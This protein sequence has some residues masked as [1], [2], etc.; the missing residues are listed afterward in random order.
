VQQS[1]YALGHSKRELERLTR[2]AHSMRMDALIGGG[3]DCV[4]Y[5]LIAEVVEA[6]LPEIER[7]RIASAAEVEIS[8]LARRMRD[9]VVARKGVVLSPG[10][11]GAWSRKNAP[12]ISTLAY[13]NREGALND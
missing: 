5:Q 2:Q 11:I 3:L 13:R 9:E 1:Q 10:L 6:L 12:L 7:Q 8:T 4:A